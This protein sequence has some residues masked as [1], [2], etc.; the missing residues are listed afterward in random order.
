MTAEMIIARK[1]A[2]EIRKKNAKMQAKSA[3]KMGE[4]RARYWNNFIKEAQGVRQEKE[5]K[6]E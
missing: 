1:R 4:S 6:Y 2:E 3:S 5:T